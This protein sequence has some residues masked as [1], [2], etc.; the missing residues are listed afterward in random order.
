[1]IRDGYDQTVTIDTC[2]LQYLYQGTNPSAP[3][4]AGY[5]GI[6]W[7]LGLLTKTN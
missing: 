4:D 7:Q 1:M 2:H 3:N 6:P 5:N